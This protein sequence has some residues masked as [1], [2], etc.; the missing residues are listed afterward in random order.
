[1]CVFYAGGEL[2]LADMGDGAFDLC[3]FRTLQWWGGTSTVMN[4]MHSLRSKYY[5]FADIFFFPIFV[6]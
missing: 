1:M 3:F 5:T 6:S 2:F 4:A